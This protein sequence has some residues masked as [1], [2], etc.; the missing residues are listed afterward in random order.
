ML[1]SAEAFHAVVIDGV[2]QPR[3]MVSFKNRFGARE[4]EALRAYIT[5]RA[6]AALPAAQPAAR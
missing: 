3:G 5:Q 2:L 4:A 1:R 6:R